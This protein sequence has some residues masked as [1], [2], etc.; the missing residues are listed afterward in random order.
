MSKLKLQPQ[1][2]NKLDAGFLAAF[3]GAPERYFS[4]PGR[5]EIGG[6]HTDHQRGRVL[7]G[8]VNLDTVAAVR[9]N[10]TDTIRILSK[11]YPMSVV[12]LK[13]LTPVAEEINSTPALIRGVAARFKELG[14]EVKG[15]DAYVESTVL[16]GSGLSSSAAFEVLVGTII[17]C[18]FFDGKVSQPEIAMIGQYAENVFFGKPCGLMDQTASAVGGMVTINFADKNAPDIQQ[19]SFDFASCGHALCIIDSGADHA[20]LT[21]EYA[22]VTQD[23]KALCAHFGKEVLTQVPEEDFYAAIPALR[24]ECGDRAV[25]RG[26]HEY[27]ENK[28]VVEQVAALR[29]GDFDRF[30]TLI[31]ES[32]YSSYMYLQN[33]IP[34]GYVQHQDMAVALGLCEHYLQGRGA[35]RVHGGGFA[36]TVQAFVPLELLEVFRAGIDGALGE[37]ACHV[38]S[39]RPQGGV[40]MEI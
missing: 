14:C 12:D 26:I 35:Y 21:D 30:L 10:G 34:A 6:N 16:A 32:G 36:G 20:D 17:N 31:K 15:F 8:A 1:Q 25:M 18:L 40:E 2:K 19:V 39:I 13:V 24:K 37:G 11:G 4:A 27:A 3:G 38:L 23:F 7:A 28:R 29:S 9:C 5:T 22:A 33:V